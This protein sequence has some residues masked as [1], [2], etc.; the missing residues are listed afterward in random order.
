MDQQAK[1]PERK[2]G[3]LTFVGLGVGVMCI[4]LVVWFLWVGLVALLFRSPGADPS[5]ALADGAA[6]IAF[7]TGVV[8]FSLVF[9]VG[10][11]LSE[12]HDKVQRLET[13]VARLAGPSGQQIPPS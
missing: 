3:A 5:G 11:R 9:R 4:P 6:L 12:L 13:T 7:L 1:A 10:Y 8:I 2:P